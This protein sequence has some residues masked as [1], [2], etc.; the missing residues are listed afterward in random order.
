MVV[1]RLSPGFQPLARTRARPLA[2][3]C[4]VCLEIRHSRFTK[5]GSPDTSFL[6]DIC[7]NTNDTLLKTA[8]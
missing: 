8:V 3:W 4:F 2:G 6:M 1:A 5:Y 7:S